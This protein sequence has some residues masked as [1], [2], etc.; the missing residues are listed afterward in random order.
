MYVFIIFVMIALAFM[1]WLPINAGIKAKQEANKQKMQNEAV[2]IVENSQYYREF[3][4]LNYEFAKNII[5][6]DY[7]QET[8]ECHSLREYQNIDLQQEFISLCNELDFNVLLKSEEKNNSI[9]RQYDDSIRT[10]ISNSLYF[11]DNST[12]N[13]MCKQ[14]F[15]HV[16]MQRK[17]P[18]SE[19]KVSVAK[20]Y[21]SPAGRNEY[22]DKY[23]HSICKARELMLKT[24]YTINSINRK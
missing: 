3:I 23:E 19:T 8:I 13:E 17:I 1:F 9:R 4:T 5:K 20:T 7:C 11:V 10:L 22:Y 12:Q 2:R 18:T 16:I 14:A 6:L 21:I 15:Q 24:N